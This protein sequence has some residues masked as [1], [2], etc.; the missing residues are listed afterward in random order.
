VV[1]RIDRSD[2]REQRLRHGAGAFVIQARQHIAEPLVGS[3]SLDFRHGVVRFERIVDDDHV[4]AS[5]GQ[6]TADRSRQAEAAG[7]KLDLA[8]RI[9]EGT[10]PRAREGRSV[11]SGTPAPRESRWSA[12]LQGRPNN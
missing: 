9:L 5:T 3:G 1:D 2:P 7:G 6:G 4:T 8:L 11:P 12:S 10:Y